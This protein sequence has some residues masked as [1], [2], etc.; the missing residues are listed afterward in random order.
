ML[1]PT[2]LTIEGLLV[3]GPG[4]ALPSGVLRTSFDPVQAAMLPWASKLGVFA[5]G[6][7]LQMHFKAP[8]SLL[9]SSKRSCSSRSSS[10]SSSSSSRSSSSTC[11]CSLSKSGSCFPNA[12]KSTTEKT[13]RKKK[14]PRPATM[15]PRPFLKAACTTR[16]LAVALKKK[17][18]SSSEALRLP[19]LCCCLLP[20]FGARGLRADG[21]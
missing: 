7:G 14:R 17:K 12:Q 10:S 4:I 2:P 18:A 8:R 19:S 9:S 1:T 20:G 5:S 13:K 16:H 21:P 15:A 11:C 6:P 3:A